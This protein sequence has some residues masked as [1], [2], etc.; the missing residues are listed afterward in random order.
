MKNLPSQFS[1]RVK[2]EKQSRE[3]QEKLFELG[4]RWR[5]GNKFYQD[6]EDRAQL[7]INYFGKE[8]DK[9]FCMGQRV[10][11]IG[12]TFEEFMEIAEQGS[13][14]NSSPSK[15]YCVPDE[16]EAALIHKW[17]EERGMASFSTDRPTFFCLGAQNGQSFDKYSRKE[18]VEENNFKLVPPHEFIYALGQIP[19]PQKPVEIEVLPWKVVIKGD[20]F[21]IGCKKNNDIALLKKEIKNFTFYTGTQEFFGMSVHFGKNQFTTGDHKSVSWETWDKFV[22][23][24]KKVIEK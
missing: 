4:Y 10:T 23:E 12:Y 20:K 9:T 19:V 11:G 22:D 24:V 2:N 18:A 17:V 6:I 8:D 5:D 7:Q 14:G 1:I 3:A 21:D 15:I 13:K 16:T